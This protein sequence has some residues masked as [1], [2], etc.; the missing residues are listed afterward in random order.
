MSGV[1]PLY[2]A[3]KEKRLDSTGK[4]H[5]DTLLTYRA[6]PKLNALSFVQLISLQYLFISLIYK[7]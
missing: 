7:D 3:L 4:C 2:F 5:T 1:Y 6:E